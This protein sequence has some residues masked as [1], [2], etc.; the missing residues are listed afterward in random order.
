MYSVWCPVHVNSSSHLYTSWYTVPVNRETAVWSSGI[1]EDPWLTNNIWVSRW[2]GRE[3]WSQFLSLW[4]IFL[5]IVWG[6]NSQDLWNTENTHRREKEMERQGGH[7]LCWQFQIIIFSR[8]L[9][10]FSD[11][12]FSHWGALPMAFTIV[13][14]QILT[15]TFNHLTDLGPDLNF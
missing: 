3:K 13:P 15:Q 12:W 9:A 6:L 10:G 2:N 14:P 5:P 4:G 1:K 8:L 7:I 11:F